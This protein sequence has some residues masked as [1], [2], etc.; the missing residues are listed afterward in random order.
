[1]DGW[2]GGWM[3][4]WVD[5][6]LSVCLFVCLGAWM[7]VCMTR[8]CA[9]CWTR[10]QQQHPLICL[11]SSPFLLC[12]A[13]SSLQDWAR[14]NSL[15]WVASK[16]ERS[17]VKRILEEKVRPS[18]MM[19]VVVW[20]WGGSIH[21]FHFS[22]LVVA[23]LLIDPPVVLRVVGRRVCWFGVGRSVNFLGGAV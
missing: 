4:G 22:F 23:S 9:R 11:S 7:S 16:E 15:E 1:M 2:V 6:G 21:H 14:A 12:L 3:G 20:W 8:P 13:S 17:L 19:K 18:T 10:Q 5:D